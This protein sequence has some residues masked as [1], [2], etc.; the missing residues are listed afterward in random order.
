MAY[1]QGMHV[2][3]DVPSLQASV[4]RLAQPLCLVPTMGALHQ[5][6]RAL[7]R[8]ARQL[9]GDAGT[10]AASIFVNPLQFD[11]G[12]DFERYPRPLEQDLAACREE[13]VDLI[14]AP[15]PSA[16]YAQDHSVVISEN[17]LSQTL[18][19]ASRPGHF[20]GV[21]TVVMKLFQVFQCH[22]AVFGE[23]DFQQ[24]AIIRRM[25]RDLHL[26]V[27]IVAHE[28]L[29]EPDGLA[30]SSRNVRLS[31][32]HRADAPC[33]RHA[34]LRAQQVHRAGENHATAIIAA[35]RNRLT[36]SPYLEVDYLSLVD[37]ER[38]V[39]VE[40]VTSPAV[41]AFAGYYGAVRLI[42]HVALGA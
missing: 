22:S 7:M 24:L 39:G 34:L 11:R 16:M 8:R 18:C 2:C 15:A 38:L 28:T 31:A 14:L 33:I 25:V 35:A 30:M 5:G 13:G 3:Y 42:D 10:V 4:A 26:P 19:G 40:F 21:C 9:V 41:L 12:D 20:A 37:A 23:K 6:H 36:A 27:Q 17:A 1:Q 29:R 32:E